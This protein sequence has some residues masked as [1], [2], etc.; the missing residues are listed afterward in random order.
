M[1]PGWVAALLAALPIPAALA[2]EPAA[3]AGYA[4]HRSLPLDAATNGVAGALQILED[5]RITPAL[6][7]DMWQQTD[8]TDL[9]LAPKD[10][11]RATFAKA[12]L[13][14]AHLRLVDASGKI[15]TDQAFE[16]PL[17]EIERRQL[18][19][20]PP[21]F[22][23]SSDHSVGTGSYAGLKTRLMMV[24]HGQLVPET[25]PGRQFLT[26]SLKNAWKIVDDQPPGAGSAKA[27]SAQPSPAKAI[28]VVACHPNFANPAWAAANE[29]VVDLTTYR[30]ADGAWHGTTASL[31]GYWESDGDWPDAFP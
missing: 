25:L 31:K 4:V 21:T 7:Q 9:V 26:S 14:P 19:D 3:P 13:Q 15:V 12:P 18:H 11:L 2:D 28:Q 27:G 8:D 6:R 5:A 29:F 16:V 24:D 30:F 17:A 22:L 23:V 10:P 1:T 20:G